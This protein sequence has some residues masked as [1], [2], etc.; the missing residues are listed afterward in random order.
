V[1]KHRPEFEWDVANLKHLARH[2]VTPTEVED[3]LENDP[4]QLGYDVVNE[5]ERWTVV[6]HTNLTR[7]LVVTWT[8][9]KGSIRVVTAWPA[10]KRMREDYF[11]FKRF[12]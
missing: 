3:V 6:G 2:R 11:R 12:P 4:A 8:L 9:R 1:P 7:V 5:E 10:P